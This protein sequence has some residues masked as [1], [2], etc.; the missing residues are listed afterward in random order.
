[1]ISETRVL[2][3]QGMISETR[4]LPWQGM[5]SETRVLPWQGMD[6]ERVIL[7]DFAED[8]HSARDG[9]RE[10]EIG[11]GGGAKAG[12]HLLCDVVGVG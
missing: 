1:M 7:S 2:P 6:F 9:D 5:I 4:V 3:W 10:R 8:Q 11:G 12:G